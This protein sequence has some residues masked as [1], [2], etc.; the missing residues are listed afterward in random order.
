MLAQTTRQLVGPDWFILVS[1]F[2]IMLG[3]GLYFFRFMRGMKDYF[4]GGNRVPWWLSGVS[5]WMSSFSAF[6]FVSYSALAYKYGMFGVTVYWVTV[7]AT[8]FSLIFFAHRW[9]RARVTSPVEYLETRYSP[10][11]RQVFAW[12]GIPV[13]LIDDALKIVA[14]GSF[15]AVSLGVR[16]EQA[17]FWSSLIMLAYTFMGGLWAV[18]VTDF[19]QFVV[20]MA[21]VLVLF[22][23]AFGE[24]GGLVHVLQTAPAERMRLITPEYD[25]VYIA[26]LILMYCF[27]YSV[28]WSLVQRFYSVPNEKEAYKVGWLVVFLNII[29]PPLMFAP[30]MAAWHFLGEVADRDVYPLMCAQLL[31][32]GMFGLVI[33]A[34]F[35]AAMSMLSSDYN[36]CASVLTNDVYKRLIRPEA[37]NRQL[38]IVGRLMTLLVGIISLGL[39]FSMVE[40]GGEELFKNMIKLFSVATAPVAVPMLLGL[41]SRRVSNGSA[42]IGFF[43]GLVV[44]LALFFMLESEVQILG[45]TLQIETAILV[46]SL[47]TTS[48]AV[49][50]SLPFFPMTAVQQQR[51]DEFHV[52]LKAPIGQLDEDNIS[53]DSGTTRLSPFRIVGVTVAIIG[54]MMLIVLPWVKA[55]PDTEIHSGPMAFALNLII[56]SAL[57]IL[58]VVMVWTTRRLPAAD[59]SPEVN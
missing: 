42:I 55:L 13:K 17:M 53:S 40:A 30:A 21:A 24:A 15:I 8:L 58:G 29:G 54:G 46:F 56:G 59:K 5:Y 3:I 44:G 41:V 34:M 22:P 2:V 1:Y 37:S 19:V 51:V 38:V 4:T 23:L 16:I 10:T 49:L 36:V 20:M 35:S 33:A 25:W 45:V 52:R 50:I 27:S 31:P 47:L 9:R 32:A 28:N 6:A 11:L 39:A 57:L 12:Q 43:V 7:P 48:A 18:M 26:G 14:I